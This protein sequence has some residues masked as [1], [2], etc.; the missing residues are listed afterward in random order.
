MPPSV[1]DGNPCTQDSCDPL[2]GVA[3]LPVTGP[4]CGSPLCPDG[5][6]LD[7]GDPTTIDR[8]D[9]TQ[10]EVHVA[11]PPVNPTRATTLLQGYHWII[12]EGIQIG[13]AAGA[14]KEST[15]SL[16]R[17]RIKDIAG[18]PINNVK[19]TVVGSP[20]FGSTTTH[21]DGT[22]DLLVNGGGALELAFD[23]TPSYLASAR[24]VNI[25]WNE[26]T[27][28]DD[29]VLLEPDA[30]VTSVDLSTLTSDYAAVVGSTMTD[31]TGVRTGTLL[32]PPGVEA[33]MI[34]ADGSAQAISELD[35]RITEFT[36][37]TNGPAAMPASIAY[38]TAYTYAFEVNADQAVQA[39]APEILFSEPLPYYVDNYYQFPVGTWIPL[40]S[41]DRIQG[42]W[43]PEQEAIV[44]KI[45]GM[46]NG[47]ALLDLTGDGAPE[48]ASA[49]AAWGIT[50]AERAKLAELCN[51][52]VYAEG[53]SLWR[54]LLPHF[55][56]PY[57]CNTGISF[58]DDS[59]PPPDDTKPEPGVPELPNPCEA[60][61]ASTIE[62]QSQVLREEIPLAGTPFKLHY[63]TAHVLGGGNVSNT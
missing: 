53:S 18:G 25:G 14:L 19:V 42:M 57:D 20:E 2:T 37:G 41:Y 13:V 22:F 48:G 56:R 23:K 31:G 50:D 16:I 1:D 35:I 62:C 12:S 39:G 28:L 33:L 45:V 24:T 46:S 63:S 40:G 47:M 27:L 9:P 10:G 58:P 11:L 26:S 30:K 54:M 4:G 5:I 6:D 38:N 17:G 59:E 7:D 52:G 61:N 51:S 32:F 15:A 29:V 60:P 21:A 3:H 36:V 43:V 44:V 49:L 55:T 34:G 8:C